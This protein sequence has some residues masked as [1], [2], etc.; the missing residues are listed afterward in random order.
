MKV[1]CSNSKGGILIESAILFPIFLMGIFFCCWLGVTWNAKSSLTDAVS[2]AVRLAIT[3][4][5]PSQAGVPPIADV[6]DWVNNKGSPD[7]ARVT[8]LLS[9]G[10]DFNDAQIYYN[11]RSLG[12]VFAGMSLNKVSGSP[13]MPLGYS[14]ALIYLYEYLKQSIGPSI[15]Y[16]CDPYGNGAHDDGAGCISCVFMNPDCKTVSG[17]NEFDAYHGNVPDNRIGMECT[18]QPA[19]FILTPLV[20]LFKYLSGN[21]NYAIPRIIL[22]RKFFYAR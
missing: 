16:P 10:V 21:Y 2:R 22:K 1:K 12:A 7:M 19:N 4:G 20:R 11:N 8:A 9:R 17:T 15:R 3:R 6:D 13:G 18:F 14:Y 5:D